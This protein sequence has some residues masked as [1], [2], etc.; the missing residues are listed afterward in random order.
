VIVLLHQFK[1]GGL[2]RTWRKYHD[3]FVLYV[4]IVGRDVLAGRIELDPS[5][6]A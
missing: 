6:N 3:F 4:D 2:N 5:V 1:I